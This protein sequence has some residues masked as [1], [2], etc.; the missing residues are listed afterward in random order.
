MNNFDLIV[1]GACHGFWIENDIKKC[2][3]KILLIEPVKY[4]FEQLKNRFKIIKIL[5]SKIL[6]LEKKMN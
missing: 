2:S 1:I 4:N 5:F 6:Q 3:N